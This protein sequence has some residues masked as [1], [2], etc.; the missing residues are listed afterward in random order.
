MSLVVAGQLAGFAFACGL[1]LYLTVAV[2]GILYRF[3]LLHGLPPG[4][5]GLE[6]WVVIGSALA[7]Y[8]VE[9]VVDRISHADSIWDAVHTLIRPPAAALLA[10]GALWGA[11]PWVVATGAALTLL[12]ALAAHVTKAG[13][14]MTLNATMRTGWQTRISVL[15]DVLAVALAVLAFRFPLPVLAAVAAALLASV[16]F[17]PGLW[18]AFLLGI[19][20]VTAWFRSI[21]QP[22]TWHDAEELPDDVRAVLDDTP[23]GAA[24]PRGARAALHDLEGAGAFQNG[25][26]VLDVHRPVFVARSP[27]GTRR[28]ELP[29]PRDIHAEDGVWAN[30]LRIQAAEGDYTLFLLKDGPAVDLAVRNLSPAS[31]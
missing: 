20:C 3:E 14:R 23:I 22:A 31:P 11:N 10:V 25:W 4:L 24:P 17:G 6:G 27:F 21:V 2:M 8:L 26:L 12:V 16:P 9:A 5:E 28:I 1:N 7:L 18:R 30:I 29:E 13:L 15:E 19:R